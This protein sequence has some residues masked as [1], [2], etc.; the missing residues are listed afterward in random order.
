MNL[1]EVQKDKFQLVPECVVAETM[2]AALAIFREAHPNSVV[3]QITDG[4]EVLMSRVP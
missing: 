4:G 2:E 1:F 3:K